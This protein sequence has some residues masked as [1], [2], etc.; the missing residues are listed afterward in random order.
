MLLHVNGKFTMKKLKSSRYHKNSL[1]TGPHC[2]FLGV[3][4]GMKQTY[5]YL[6]YA[7][8]QTEKGRFDHQSWHYVMKRDNIYSGMQ[9]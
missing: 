2:Q 5:L 8:F 9:D 1:L 7:L 3:G 6:W 4:Q